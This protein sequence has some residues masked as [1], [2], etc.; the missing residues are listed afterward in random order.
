VRSVCYETFCSSK[1][2]TIKID[3]DYIVCPRAGGKIK[4]AN[5]EGYL[6]CPDYN[7]MCSGTVLCNDIFD[8][9]EKKSL[10]KDNAYTY[11]YTIQTSQNIPNSEDQE[12]D[13]IN[14]YELSDDGQCPQFCKLCTGNQKCLECKE[15]YVLV[16]NVNDEKIECVHRDKVNIGGY[17]TDNGNIYYECIQ[18]CD[19]C[20]NSFTCDP[21]NSNAIY[22][23]NKCIIKINN[24]EEYFENGACEKCSSNYAFVEDNKYNCVNINSLES[25]YTKDNGEMYYKCDGIL[26]DSIQDCNKC[27]YNEKLECDKCKNNYVLK[28]NNI[29]K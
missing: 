27:H 15:D 28:N 4:V 17:Y 9:V 11:D 12:V 5:Y 25:Y 13:N 8:C 21:C 24:C 18:N 3:D 7:L 1:S 20:T 22:L 2:L 23:F 6:L 10:I 19:I 26:Y 16:G 14:N 29:N